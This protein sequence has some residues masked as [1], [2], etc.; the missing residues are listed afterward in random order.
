MKAILD[1]K[2]NVNVSVLY[3]ALELSNKKWKLG[4]SNGEKVRQVVIEAGDLAALKGQIMLA[5]AKLRLDKGCPVRSCYEAG[6]DGFW[7]HRHLVE[8]GVDNAVIDS[9][10]I[11]VNRRRRRAK[12]DGMDVQSLL[13]LLIRYWA[14]ERKVMSIV[15]VPSIEAEDQRRLHRERERLLKERGAHSAR[16]ISLLVAGKKTPDRSVALPQRGCHPGRCGF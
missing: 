1:S 15:R 5:K 6:R 14:G 2:D 13:R 12:T 16:I 7:L 4:F 11:E 8:E 9:A 10:S 3:I